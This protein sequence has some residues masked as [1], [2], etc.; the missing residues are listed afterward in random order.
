MLRAR[1]AET[2][3]LELSYFSPVF[4][5]CVPINLSGPLMSSSFKKGGWDLGVLR[6]HP[7]QRGKKRW[8]RN[9]W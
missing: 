8:E 9:G 1:G 6:F 3:C 5:Y 2:I 4:H 7:E